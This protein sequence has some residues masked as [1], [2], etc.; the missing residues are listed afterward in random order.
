MLSMLLSLV[1]LGA[2][3]KTR[4]ETR[5]RNDVIAEILGYKSKGDHLKL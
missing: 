4:W 3:R 2:L 1:F 5:L